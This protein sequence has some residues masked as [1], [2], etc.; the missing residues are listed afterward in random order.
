MS[1]GGGFPERVAKI[2]WLPIPCSKPANRV[3]FDDRLVRVLRR[4]FG[5]QLVL[6]DG[7]RQDAARTAAHNTTEDRPSPRQLV[8]GWSVVGK[9]LPLAVDTVVIFD[10]VITR[11]ASFK[12]AQ[13]IIR[14]EYP[15]VAIKG[16]FLARSVHAT[17]DA[18]LFSMMN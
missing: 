7:I 5:Q 13:S 4:A 17:D 6:L 12:A 16:V 15:D 14:K 8:D 2:A 10:D 1:L 9:Q 18:D 11:G 3:E